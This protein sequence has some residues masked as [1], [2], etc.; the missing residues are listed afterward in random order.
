VWWQHGRKTFLY[1]LTGFAALFLLIH[2]VYWPNIL[3]LWAYWIPKGLIPG[4]E[5]FYTPWDKFTGIQATPSW[6]WLTNLD[7]NTWNPII[8]FW[9]GVRFNF[10]VMVGV[11]INLLL[12]PARKAWPDRFTFRAAVFL[13]AS[14]LVLL[15]VHMWAALDEQSCTA[16]CFSGYVTFFNGIGILA[17]V[18]TAPYWRRTLHWAYQV[19]AGAVLVIA[20]AGIGFGAADKI[21][22]F[23]AELPVPRLSGAAPL[24]GYFENKFGTSFRD[25]RKI[26]PAI[27]GFAAGVALLLA[28]IPIGRWKPVKGFSLAARALL[29]FFVLGYLLAPT[30]LLSLG[31]ETLTCGGN[32]IAA[33]R[34]VGAQLAP[35]MAAGEKLYYRGPNSPA[36]LLYL[37]RV[38]IYPPQLNNVF[39][40]SLEENGP[41]A[42]EL[43]RFGY[44]NQELKDRWMAEAD[45]VLI[46]DRQYEEWAPLVEAGELD[47]VFV[48]EPL[49]PCRGKD[50]SL[51]LL[52]RVEESSFIP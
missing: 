12:W 25:A 6:A 47:T 44:W 28:A 1:G 21:G 18:I 48:S 9:Q 40:F 31:D 39:S 49:E 13:N 46:E 14:F 11:L 26:I 41:P 22:K 24:W 2:I 35:L 8:S 52:R 45:V 7:D 20:T 4:L 32:L 43:L 34:D 19:L 36:I 3:R 50:S 5:A 17:I 38:E 30:P 37:P 10:V 15:A 33:Y 16:F 51:I 23:L 27:A 29:A 42:D